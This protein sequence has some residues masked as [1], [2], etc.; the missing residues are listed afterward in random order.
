MK[1]SNNQLKAII[2]NTA[3]QTPDSYFYKNFC[4]GKKSIVKKEDFVRFVLNSQEF[5]QIVEKNIKS[6][7]SGERAGIKCDL[8]ELIWDNQKFFKSYPDY[9]NVIKAIQKVSKE[10]ELARRDVLGEV[11]ALNYIPILK[12]LGY[13]VDKPATKK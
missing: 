7:A 6:F 8:Q 10:N 4:S 13:K 11:M 1:L 3:D 9:K 5:N 2:N 12:K